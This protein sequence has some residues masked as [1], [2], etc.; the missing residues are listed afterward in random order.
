M[1]IG[2]AIDLS[3]LPA[4][5]VVE[6]I[7]YETILKEGLTDFHA[8]MKE[9]G[10]EYVVLESDP[11][12]KLAEAFAYR[13]ML[14]RQTSNEQALAVL[15][16]YA[17]NKDLDHKA[18]ERNLERKTISAETATEKAVL[19]IDDSLRRRVQ[20]APESY[21]TAGSEGSYIFHGINA[22]VRVKDILPFAPLDAEGFPKGICNIYVLSNEADGSAPEDLISI[23]NQS[24]NKK[25]IRPLTDFVQVY[26]ASIL[27]YGIQ[28][29]IE[30]GQGP[31]ANVILQSAFTEI[32]K[33]TA[34]VHAFGSEPSLSGI[35]QALHRP[36]V[37]KVN[38]IS[39]VANI[40]TQLGQVAFCDSFNI[41]LKEVTSHE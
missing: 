30:I 23:V 9:L 2:S 36:G 32:R 8:R 22:D 34:Q 11:A 18:A 38:L 6:Q 10:I 7:D 1:T 35:Y 12:Y 21:T 33:Y 5:D 13:E 40:A 24:L 27:K 19:E 31:D 28:A 25:A 4:P 14:V 41:Y 3:Q 29:E 16:A 39:P 15:L 26:S 37:T 17:K 20:M